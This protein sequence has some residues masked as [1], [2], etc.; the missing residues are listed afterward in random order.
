TVVFYDGFHRLAHVSLVNG[1]AS[2]SISSLSPG[3]HILRAGYSGSSA[4]GLSASADITQIVA[5]TTT[6]LSSNPNPSNSGQQVT[7]TAQ[8]TGTGP[9]APTGT[10]KFLDGTKVLGSVTL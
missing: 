1:S 2:I 5:P 3:V 6:T 10:V 4:F 9:N 8:V 7:F